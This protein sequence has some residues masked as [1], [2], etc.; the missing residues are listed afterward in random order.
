MKKINIGELAKGAD[1]GV[2]TI[3]YYE[4]R[5]LIPKPRRTDSGYRQYPPD[6]VARVKFIKRAQELGF[7]LKEITEL[8]SLKSEETTDCG[9]TKSVAESKISEIENKIR[10]LRE[11]KKA[12]TKVVEIC[13]GQGP[14]TD[15][16][17]LEIMETK[18]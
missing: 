13:P 9:D 12:L 4:R 3:R 5:G 6:T 17:I 10:T 16:P 14:L 1:V 18:E 7:S 2:Q 11:M 8:I 15:Y